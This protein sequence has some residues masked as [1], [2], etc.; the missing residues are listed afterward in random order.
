MEAERQFVPISD[1]FGNARLF[2]AKGALDERATLVKYF[3]DEMKTPAQRM[4]VRLSYIKNIG[5]LYALQSQYK[6]RLRRPCGPCLGNGMTAACTHSVETARKYFY[7]MTKT[8]T[9]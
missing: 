3:C 5:D 4:G 9:I 1:L 8:H 7:W 2:S 6:D